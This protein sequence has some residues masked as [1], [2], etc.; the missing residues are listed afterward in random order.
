[1]KK[2]LRTISLGVMMSIGAIA[3]GLIDSEAKSVI[4]V[5]KDDIKEKEASFRGS[6]YANSS[7][8]KYTGDLK[9]KNGYYYEKGTIPV[10]ISA[11]HTIVQP[12]RGGYD[13]GYG[14]KSADKLTGAMA[15]I[16][17]EKTGAHV[18]YKTRYIEGED[19]NY[20]T[21]GTTAYRDKLSQIVKD[22]DIKFVVDLH[23]YDNKKKSHS[24]VLGTNDYKNLLGQEEY[25]DLVIKALNEHEFYLNGK[26]SK[27][28]FVIDE[29]FKASVKNRTVANYSATTL[30][31]PAIQMEFGS[32]LR[33]QEDSSQF[34][35]AVNTVI[36]IINN[37]DEYILAE[38]NLSSKVEG[39]IANTPTRVNLRER[40]TINSDSLSKIYVGERVTI[41]ES[42]IGSWTKVKYQNTVGYVSSKYI[43]VLSDAHKEGKVVGVN[44][45]I[46]LR[47]S[48]YSE[49]P[50]KIEKVYKNET[51]KI[52]SD[53][54]KNYYK[55]EYLNS[56]NES[57]KGYVNKKY[58]ELV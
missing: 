6:K 24:V 14:Y 19:E 44:S 56:K 54:N 13:N 15:K 43:N 38:K 23:G 12:S 55:V 21:S 36:D 50:N 2:M 7:T 32:S 52:L 5:S 42:N 33:S 47:D 25:L 46:A 26:Y 37:I 34:S 48:A 22:N 28:K 41:L 53:T 45:Y 35:R 20:V 40:A 39:V 29:E 1:M 3:P 58:I 27:S 16:I 57:I 18:I 4:L 9:D 49:N 10:L 51:V 17:A 31:V 30:N 11:P 8:Y